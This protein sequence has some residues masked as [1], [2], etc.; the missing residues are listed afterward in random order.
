M[1]NKSTAKEMLKALD[2]ECCDVFECHLHNTDGK[3]ITL[4]PDFE[5]ILDQIYNSIAEEIDCE[6][7]KIE[8]VDEGSISHLYRQ[9]YNW[10]VNKN[11]D[12]KERL[13]K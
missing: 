8:D 7:R 1:I 3:V 4:Y 2:S 6:E 5:A 12:F 11:K 9:G 13:L 10:M